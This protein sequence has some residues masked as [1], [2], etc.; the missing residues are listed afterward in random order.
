[1][2]KAEIV[3]VH[4]VLKGLRQGFV[5]AADQQTRFITRSPV[6][7]KLTSEHLQENGPQSCLHRIRGKSCYLM[8]V[9]KIFKEINEMKLNQI[10]LMIVLMQI[11]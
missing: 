7:T 4:E 1:M 6:V 2:H 10:F 5:G 11:V 8:S 9:W 3:V